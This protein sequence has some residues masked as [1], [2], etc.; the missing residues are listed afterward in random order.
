MS[1]KSRKPPRK[2]AQVARARPTAS[3]GF[4]M[5]V[6]PEMRQR[7]HDCAH[8]LGQNATA[9]VIDLISREC[10]RV[11]RLKREADR[12]GMALSDYIRSLEDLGSQTLLHFNPEISAR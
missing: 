6:S 4:Y 9:W 2:S 5:R 12:R 7:F 3:A 8:L 11:E 10:D 1:V